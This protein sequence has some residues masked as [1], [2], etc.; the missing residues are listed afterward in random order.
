MII[1]YC[2]SVHWRAGENS[3][4][5]I[6]ENGRKSGEQIVR[7]G[8]VE[9]SLIVPATVMANALPSGPAGQRVESRRDDAVRA[10]VRPCAVALRGLGHVQTDS[11]NI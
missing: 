4:V 3:E 10:A 8:Q 7:T 1:S 11:S 9:F 6:T 2:N 5:P